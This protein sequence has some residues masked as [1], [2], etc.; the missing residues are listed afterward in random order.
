MKIIC[1]GS[2]SSGN[3]YLLKSNGGETLM[4]E[5]GIDFR[6]VKKSLNFDISNI[7]GCL[8][9]HE[10][11]D[12]SKY[13]QKVMNFGI[14]CYMSNGTKEVLAL[15]HH[16]AIILGKNQIQTIG[17]YEIMAFSTKHDCA[18]PIGFLIHHREMGLMVFATDTYYLEYSFEGLNHIFI[19]CNYSKDI[20]NKNVE[21]GLINKTL[22]DR[23]LK[24]HFELGNVKDF[25]KA[26]DL[27]SVRN[28]CLL[29][30]S[31]RNSDAERFKKEIEEFTS[32]NVVIADKD[33]EIDLNLFPF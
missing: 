10:H 8:I 21:L 12:H 19:E 7:S 3:C 18:D 30:L 28:I 4:L 2:S 20:L 11:G 15:N 32:K 17:Q 16:R 6:E 33:V 25:M 27:S 9:T 1:L 5:C 14:E 22:R 26:N 24:S 31:D 13:L 29:H 23:T